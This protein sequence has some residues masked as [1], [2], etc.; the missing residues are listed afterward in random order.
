MPLS[1]SV[2]KPLGMLGFTAAVSAIDAAIN[3]K[4]LRS[5]TITLIISN[6]EMNEVLKIV[7]SL[8]DSGILLKGVSEA[9]KNEAKEQK[10]R[11]LGML[12]GTL[13]ASLLG[14]MLS[15]KGVI[16]AGEGAIRAFYGSIKFWLPIH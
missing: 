9:I 14:N 7:K 8:E 4:I 2:I 15:G 12:F 1:I 11:F 5:G 6:D 16:G 10:G 3:K 13:G